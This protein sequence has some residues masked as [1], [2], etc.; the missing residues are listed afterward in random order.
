M[1]WNNELSLYGDLSRE[2]CTVLS[3]RSAKWD[4]S[5]LFLGNWGGGGGGGGGAICEMKYPVMSVKDEM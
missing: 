4:F 2:A 1:L 3:L 5:N